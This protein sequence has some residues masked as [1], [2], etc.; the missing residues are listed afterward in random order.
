MRVS[1]RRWSHR[2]ETLRK[3]WL[4]TECEHGDDIRAAPA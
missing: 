1:G 2:D 4:A 3:V